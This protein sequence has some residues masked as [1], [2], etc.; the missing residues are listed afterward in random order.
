M[1]N[2][3]PLNMFMT[4]LSLTRKQNALLLL[5]AAAL[6][7]FLFAYIL[8]Y[9]YQTK[10]NPVLDN[11]NVIESMLVGR[12]PLTGF[13][14]YEDAGFPQVYSV[15]IDNHVDAWPQSGVDRA[16]LVYEAPVEA[17]IPRLLA[18]FYDGQVVEKIGPIRSAR[19]Y[20]IDWNNGLDALYTHVGGS[21]AALDKI[22]SSGTLDMNQYWLDA[23]FW[24]A[25]DRY[26][27]HNVYTS[28]ERVHTFI[29][30]KQTQGAFTNPLYDSWLFKDAEFS[31]Q[32]SV[33]AIKLT[34]LAPDY[35]VQW[36][37]LPEE[38]RYKRLHAGSEHVMEDSA[39]LKADTI[40]VVVTEISIMDSIGRRQLKTIGTGTAFIFQDGNVIEGTWKKISEHQRLR[41]YDE[42]E[43]E[44]AFNPGTT[45]IEVIPS[46]TAL[47]F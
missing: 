43:Q 29:S 15:M 17:G 12:H 7:A 1:K 33:D 21:N 46:Q 13:P 16:F 9:F 28:S 38:D 37:F 8:P 47:E 14:V 23:Y 19:P 20:F 41:F 32:G 34:F 3:K 4:K 25:N 11:G 36:E 10:V 31:Q 30:L 6:L 26:A 22:A 45:W 27:P 2:P 18:F 35:V 44:V 42:S 5:G 24:R 40:A 39:Q